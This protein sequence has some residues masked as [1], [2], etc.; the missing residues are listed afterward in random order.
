MKKAALCSTLILTTFGLALTSTLQA[1]PPTPPPGQPFQNDGD[2]GNGNTSE[3]NQALFSL[4]SGIANSAFGYQTLFSNTSGNYNTALGFQAL[5]YNTTAGLADQGADWNGNTATGY[6]A[7]YSNSTGSGNVANGYQALYSNTTGIINTAIGRFA[8]MSN[9]TGWRNTATGDAALFSNTTGSLN[10]ATGHSAL[11]NTNGTGNIA[12]GASA[13]W[14]LD[15]S[16]N[17]NI[18]IGTPGVTGDSNTIRIGNVRANHYHDIINTP[19]PANTDT[20]IAGIFGSS[21]ITPG[22][23]VYVDSTGKLGTLPSSRR[24]KQD[25]TPMDSTSEQIFALKPITFRYKREVT[26]D[27][28][29]QFGLVAEQVAEVNPDLVVRDATGKIQS[30]RY[31]AVNAMMLNELIKEHQKVQGLQK[32]IETLTAQLNE[33][34]AVLQKV[35]NQVELLKAPTQTV[36]TK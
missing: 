17:N 13:G 3:G 11:E 25:V 31:E 24:F 16:D 18:D 5:Y 9:Q 2:R 32:K 27:T 7:L 36:A 34:A 23:P 28:S 1:D 26:K 30:V 21:T 19:H 35:S 22:M 10:T 6:Q 8:L 29:P 12:L 14:N 20:Y 15:E 33:Q 4:T